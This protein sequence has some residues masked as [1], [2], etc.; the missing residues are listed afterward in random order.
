[1]KKNKSR[2]TTA[3]LLFS[4]FIV[5]FIL[6]LYASVLSITSANQ[7]QYNSDELL[8]ASSHENSKNIIP[9]GSQSNPNHIISINS[10]SEMDAYFSGNSTDG[11]SWGSAYVIEN[12][13]FENISETPAIT[14]NGTSKHLIIKNL[15]FQSVYAAVYLIDCSNVR[16]ENVSVINSEFSLYAQRTNNSLFVDNKINNNKHGIILE[17]SD[18]NQI[19]GNNCSYNLVNGIHLAFSNNNSINSN[20]AS[21][22]MYFG[23]YYYDSR[24]NTANNNYFGGNAQKGIMIQWK[25]AGDRVNYFDSNIVNNDGAPS[26][27]GTIPGYEMPIAL[28]VMLF[29]IT[30]LYKKMKNKIR[31][32]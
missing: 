28:I 26:I 9:N 22:N 3:D 27:P 17:S 30:G 31:F 7:F 13:V 20:N 19:S 6:S 16:I 12:L 1:M 11:N 10:N 4:A 25:T 14:I 5:L 15:A 21:F 24:N 18:F 8:A 32:A 2:I 29:S 23:L